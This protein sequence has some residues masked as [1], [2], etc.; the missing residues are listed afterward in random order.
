MNQNVL[1]NPS[2]VPSAAGE[3]GGGMLKWVIV[4]VVIILIGAAGYW[5]YANYIIGTR[6]QTSPSPSAEVTEAI[7]KTKSEK[8]VK[9][10]LGFYLESSSTADGQIQTKKARDLLTIVAQARLETIKDANGQTPA[11]LNVK[12]NLFLGASEKAKSFTIVSTQ[13]IDES[14][15]EVKVNLNY[16]SPK[17]KVFTVLSENNIWLIDAVKDYDL[18]PSVN[19]VSPSPSSSAT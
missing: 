18:S 12:L 9:D 4:V 15:V 6:G 17:L 11:D 13:K 10:F 7:W 14:K 19:P 2:G 1:E 5:Y 8:T 3:P 16:A